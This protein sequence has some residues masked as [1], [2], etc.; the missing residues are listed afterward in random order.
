MFLS[1]LRL[2]HTF[3]TLT[4]VAASVTSV[5]C[6]TLCTARLNM[7]S[8]RFRDDRLKLLPEVP[9]VPVEMMELLLPDRVEAR[10]SED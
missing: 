5:G 9:E 7:G 4:S 10:S 6:M 8:T 1:S 3:A 2:E